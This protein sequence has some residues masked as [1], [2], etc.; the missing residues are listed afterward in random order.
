MERLLTRDGRHDYEGTDYMS[1]KNIIPRYCLCAFSLA[2]MVYIVK[3]W[4]KLRTTIK[5]EKG[6][7][8]KQLATIFIASYI[9]ALLCVISFVI[10]IVQADVIDCDLGLSKCSVW[11][12]HF[13][14]CFQRL[15]MVTYAWI[16]YPIFIRIW[17]VVYNDEKGRE[18]KIAYYIFLYEIIT[19]AGGWL[20]CLWNFF[21][22]NPYEEAPQVL[23]FPSVLGVVGSGI[24]KQWFCKKMKTSDDQSPEQQ[25]LLRNLK[26]TFY[27]YCIVQSAGVFMSLL[28]LKSKNENS[29]AAAFGVFYISA[30]IY[31]LGP[32]FKTVWLLDKTVGKTNTGDDLG[33]VM[34]TQIA[35]GTQAS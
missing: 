14:G 17:D 24:L 23:N 19:G 2:C 31:V 9:S 5:S 27:P 32:A 8:K 33:K 4:S 10:Q 18:K 35:I 26:A 1:W 25:W 13:N 3:V 29:E 21:A 28:L 12:Y 15:S 30:V 11:Y 34:P 20:H 16:W 22:M 7:S 6:Q